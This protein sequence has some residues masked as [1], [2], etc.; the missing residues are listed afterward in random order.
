M[1]TKSV[2]Q[3]LTQECRNVLEAARAARLEAEAA[4]A[5]VEAMIHEVQHIRLGHQ[6]LLFSISGFDD[7]D[8]PLN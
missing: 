8:R 4:N 3:R 5:D 1:D 7:D 6:R 2:S